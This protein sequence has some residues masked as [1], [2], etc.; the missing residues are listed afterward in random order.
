MNLLRPVSIILAILIA[1]ALFSSFYTVKIHEQ[2]VVTQFQKPVGEP[3]VEP[4]LKFKLPFIQKANYFD[5]RW[6]EWDGDPN[7]IP[8]LDKKYIWVDTYARW[9]ID[10]ALLFF[11]R[12]RNE[13]SAQSRLDDILDGETRVAISNY[14]LIEIVR[15][16]N[17]E[18]LVPEEMDEL[19]ELLMQSVPIEHGRDKIMTEIYQNA[20]S[21][22]AE[23]GIE[24]VD[25]KIKRIN[26]IP[27]VREKV[28]ERMISERKRIADKYRSEGQ[29]QSAEIL[30]EM[31]KELRRIQSEAVREAQKLKGAADAEAIRIYAEAYQQDP[32]FYAFWKSLDTLRETA[33]KNTRLVLS[34]DNALYRYL[35]TVDK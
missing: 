17:R 12:I 15:S 33:D 26:Y 3:I 20:R 34:T 29:G 4:G 13:R 21:Q 10:D 8:T 16:S 14:K 32:D 5:K 6:L 31:E 11:K 30:G 18:F 25:F 28:Y 1:A 24:L 22:A 35:N 27:D 19:E 2:I 9:R 23:Y 7:Q